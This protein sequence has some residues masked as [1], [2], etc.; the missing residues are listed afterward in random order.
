MNAEKTTEHLLDQGVICSVVPIPGGP[1]VYGADLTGVLY[2]VGFD[3]Y[4]HDGTVSLCVNTDSGVRFGGSLSPSAARHLANLLNWK[5]AIA[6]NGG[7]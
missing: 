6:E 1:T 4:A 3:A 7:E 5:A 2:D